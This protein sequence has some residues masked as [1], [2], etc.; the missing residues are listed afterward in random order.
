MIREVELRIV[1]SLPRL[2]CR[3]V[4]ADHHLI[5][6]R[7]V[8]TT[9]SDW[10]QL[11]DMAQQACAAIGGDEITVVADRGC[12]GRFPSNRRHMHLPRQRRVSLF[13]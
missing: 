13:K 11:V 12:E 3:S 2:E 5:I 7:E 4:N 6:A 9:G 10:A 8:V 1:N